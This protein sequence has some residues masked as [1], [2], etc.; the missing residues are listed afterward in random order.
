MSDKVRHSGVMLIEALV[1]ILILSFGLLGLV[2]L[3]AR[4]IQY[5]VSAEDSNR[6]AL[7]ANEIASTMQASQTVSLSTTVTNAWKARVGN[8]A[9]SGL[10]NGQ[11]AIATSGNVAT[12]TITWRATSATAGA[13]N[14]VNRYVTHVILP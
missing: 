6:A 11:G 14:S 3:Q 8:P 13:A 9:G 4:A 7:L 5:S 10:P 12:I 2:S 1:C